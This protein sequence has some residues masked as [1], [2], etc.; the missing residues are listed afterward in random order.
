M[1]TTVAKLLCTRG[2]PDTN[3]NRADKPGPL[4]HCSVSGI[5]RSKGSAS[6]DTCQCSI[7][8]ILNLSICTGSEPIPARPAL[9]RGGQNKIRHSPS[10]SAAFCFVASYR[11]TLHIRVMSGVEGAAADGRG[12]MD[13]SPALRNIVNRKGRPETRD[14]QSP[15]TA[16]HLLPPP[17]PPP[18]SSH[19]SE[20]RGRRGHMPISWGGGPLTRTA[21]RSVPKAR[22]AHS[23]LSEERSAR[24]KTDPKN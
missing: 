7:Q 23:S 3:Q 16:L 11:G 8:L 12:R 4:R 24:S 21:T 18:S 1:P 13:R 6:A 22:N 2:R 9:L 14:S 15:I 20:G 17:P 5:T 19:A 10:A